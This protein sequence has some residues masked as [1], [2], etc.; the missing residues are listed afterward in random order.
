MNK[1]RA[2]FATASLSVMHALVDFLCAATLFNPVAVEVGLSQ[3]AFPFFVY[4]TLAF[5]T[6]GIFGVLIDRFLSEYKHHI[7]R[8]SVVLILCGFFIPCGVYGRILLIGIGNSI[9]HVAAGASILASGSKAVRL[10]I[11][12]A[13]GAIG[14]TLGTLYPKVGIF[15]A[16]MLLILALVTPKLSA[17][18]VTQRSV[19][20]PNNQA[21]I[22]LLLLLC[23]ISR[24]LVGSAVYYP[25]KNGALMTILLTLFVFGGKVL[26]GV[27]IDRFGASKTG[28]AALIT[29]S[30]LVLFCSSYALP[31]MAGQF[32]VNISMP[33]TLWLLYLLLPDYPGFAFGLAASA[34]YPGTLLG[35]L[36]NP[37]SNNQRL[38]I[39]FGVLLL[40]A[41]ILVYCSHSFGYKLLKKDEFSLAGQNGGRI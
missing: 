7:V 15:I 12:V 31:S 32:L 26:G 22:V 34:L 38:L 30:A 33:L 25:W 37:L 6:Q 9:F 23:I 20:R 41:V 21:L 39:V 27:F 35:A 24:A 11:F 2:I 13:P 8:V 14:L 17:I 5:T 18:S 1:R 29:A 36:L 10:G 4:N 16:P 40:N 19:K 3:M 28:A